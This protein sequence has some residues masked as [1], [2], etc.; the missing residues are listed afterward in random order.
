MKKKISEL[1]NYVKKTGTA[2][3]EYMV[4]IKDNVHSKGNTVGKYL[5]FGNGPILEEFYN[6]GFKYNSNKVKFIKK[7]SC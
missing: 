6:G 1:E 2:E 4:I 5:A 7:E 3:L